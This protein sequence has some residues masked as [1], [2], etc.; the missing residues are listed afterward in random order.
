MRN[1][2]M[3][4]YGE[5]PL[6]DVE[7]RTARDL[8]L[9]NSA[10]TVVATDLAANGA[11]TASRTNQRG[12]TPASRPDSPPASSARCRACGCHA[13]AESTVAASSDVD[14]LTAN[15]SGDQ[16][17]D[18]DAWL[19]DRA[20]PDDLDIPED[21]DAPA[22]PRFLSE[23]D[24]LDAELDELLG[25]QRFS[26]V[27]ALEWELWEGVD[28]DEA[29]REMLRRT[30]PAWV[31]LPPGG[32]LA[33]ALEETRPQAM[34]P[35]ALIELIKAANRLSGWAEAIKA[36]AMASFVRQRRAEHH[37]SPR[38]TQLDSK[39]R[40]V[41][42]ERSWY[43]EIALALGLS[44][45]TVGRRVDTAL[46]LTS[47]LSAT[48]TALRCGALTWGKALAI[49]EATSQLPD[50][51]A[52]AV[53]AHVLKRAASQTHRNLLESLRR[54]VAKHTT[55]QA[56][57]EHRAAAAERTCKIVPLPNGM[58]GLWIVHT[59]DKIQQIWIAIQAMAALAKRGTPAANPQAG[60]S[61][62][63]RHGNPAHPEIPHQSDSAHPN[64]PLR[65]GDSTHPD[66][67]L[68]LG[69]STR[70][71]N[72]QRQDDLL[73]QADSPRHDNAVCHHDSLRQGD[74]LRHDDPV[75][76]GSPLHQDTS[77][78]QGDSVHQDNPLCQDVPMH[79]DNPLYQDDPRRQ[80]NPLYQDDPRHQD[81]PLYQDD[82]THQDNRLH[83]DDPVHR[84]NPL[85]QDNSLRQG[86]SA[87][88]GNAPRHDDAVR[89]DN[90]LHH[91]DALHHDE[92]LCQADSARQR[93]PLRANDAAYE[94][95]P[96]RGAGS[97]DREDGAGR[98][99]AVRREGAARQETPVQQ[100]GGA[101]DGVVVKD[102]R[103]AQ[104]R[105]ADVAADLFEQILH[106]GLDWLGRRLPDQHRRRPHI[107]VVVPASTLLGLDDDPAPLAG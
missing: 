66:I 27:D 24:M 76:Q 2:A 49:S 19:S 63:P 23:Q 92:A 89:Q 79:Q 33:T 67:P 97:G 87:R 43:G 35:M 16:E 38:P 56:A 7:S 34:S 12:R 52:Q 73:G 32:A 83:Q 95:S 51:A 104:Q 82:P 36:N 5:D 103:T 69:D 59:A 48:H 17:P 25:G 18:L 96:S 93:N 80:D 31:L 20:M 26:R 42:P 47:T 70:Q 60:Q 99:N 107:E 6:V 4:A 15:Q 78:R 94:V 64:T 71:D 90:L 85:H 57:E 100:D 28:Q 39:G 14:C 3:L 91:D 13:L 10:G 61:N 72:P 21:P 44:P 46:R 106:N 65:L 41:D 50:D 101:G 88:Q 29:E 98:H 58:A 84:D 1:P 40:V 37:E 75:D 74:A 62:S 86:D 54:Q 102:V 11:R 81:N 105:R 55:A 9:L 8:Q 77:L 68:R 22:T 45:D 53:E 30:A